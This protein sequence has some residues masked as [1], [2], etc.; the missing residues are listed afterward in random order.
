MNKAQTN[1]IQ[2]LTTRIER[3]SHDGSY[4][5]SAEVLEGG[6]VLFSATNVYGGL[7]WYERTSDCYMLIGPR[8][9]CR[10]YAGNIT[11]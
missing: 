1:K 4:I 6:T 11:L 7:K 10:K 9:G 5:Y 3:R 2:S 8:G